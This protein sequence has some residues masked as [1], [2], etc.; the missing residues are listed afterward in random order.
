VKNLQV[1]VVVKV[2]PPQMQTQVIPHL[3]QK[4]RMKKR[5]EEEKSRK[6]KKKRN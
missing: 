4:V 5:K 6:R 2:H 3:P 1:V